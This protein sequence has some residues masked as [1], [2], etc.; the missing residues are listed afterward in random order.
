MVEHFDY[1]PGRDYS[2][3]PLLSTAGG[4]ERN[5]LGV[6]PGRSLGRGCCPHHHHRNI[7]ICSIISSPLSYCS[8]PEQV[9]SLLP[10]LPVAAVEESSCT[11]HIGEPEPHTKLYH[12]SQS[13]PYRSPFLIACN[14]PLSF[15]KCLIV[16]GGPTPPRI[17]LHNLLCNGWGRSGGQLKSVD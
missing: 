9:S 3:S 14:G 2:L 5:M 4:G 15:W 17:P 16:C 6:W 12:G 1:F 10:V 13:I 11:P 8:E 7:G